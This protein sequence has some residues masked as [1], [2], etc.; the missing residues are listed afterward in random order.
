MVWSPSCTRENETHGVLTRNTIVKMEGSIY[1]GY[2]RDP[3]ACGEGP[4]LSME[5]PNWELGPHV[6]IHMRDPTR[7]REKCVLLDTLIKVINKSL[8]L[9]CMLV[10]L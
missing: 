8:Y 1:E 3:L 6:G 5:L 2:S 7:T 10:S 4:R 9:C